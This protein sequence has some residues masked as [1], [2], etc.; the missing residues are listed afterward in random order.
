[1]SVS[2]VK[3]LTR[4]DMNSLIY[5]VR[6]TSDAVMILNL[7]GALRGAGGSADQAEGAK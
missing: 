4:S 6:L 3:I 2:A 1:M 7:M 5:F